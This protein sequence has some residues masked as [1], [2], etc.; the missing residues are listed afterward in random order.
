MDVFAPHPDP[1]PAEERIDMQHPAILLVLQLLIS[2]AF[3]GS[4]FRLHIGSRYVPPTEPSG[5]PLRWLRGQDL[6]KRVPPS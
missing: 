4:C 6:F 2:L 1:L 5:E 3:P